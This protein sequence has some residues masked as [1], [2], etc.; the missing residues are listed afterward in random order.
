MKPINGSTS[1]DALCPSTEHAPHNGAR[2]LA[3][4]ELN[5]FL[6]LNAHCLEFTRKLRR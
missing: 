3:R 1:L 5:L 4:G 2:V 6:R